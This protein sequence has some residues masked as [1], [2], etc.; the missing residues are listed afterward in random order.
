[1]TTCREECVRAPTRSCPHVSPTGAGQCMHLQVPQ[2]QAGH[3]SLYEGLM[4][5]VSV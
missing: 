4:R 1:M 2:D 3:E 5:A